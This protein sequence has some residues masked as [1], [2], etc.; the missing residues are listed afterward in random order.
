[1]FL[2]FPLPCIY[3]CIRF[4]NNGLFI[5]IFFSFIA[6]E[7]WYF[8]HVYWPFAIVLLQVACVC[9]FFK[10]SSTLGFFTVPLMPGEFSAHMVVLHRLNEISNVWT[11]HS[12]TMVKDI[13]SRYKILRLRFFFFQPWDTVLM[14]SGFYC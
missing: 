7:V 10:P 6:S 11:Y 1:M 3:A 5:L 12:L 2:R 14:P 9:L 8:S 4:I 13:L